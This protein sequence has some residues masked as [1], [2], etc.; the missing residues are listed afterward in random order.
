[1]KNP[2]FSFLRLLRAGTGGGRSPSRHELSRASYHAPSP[3]LGGIVC[4]VACDQ[5]IRLPGQSQGEKGPVIRV[6]QVQVWLRCRVNGQ[7][8]GLDL[9]QHLTD[10]FQV[11]LEPW[12]SEP[13]RILGRVVLVVIDLYLM[14]TSSLRTPSGCGFGRCCADT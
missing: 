5:I 4:Q 8:V 12:A 2:E 10:L 13:V 1:M 11:E 9:G 3:A 7:A 14:G 6:R